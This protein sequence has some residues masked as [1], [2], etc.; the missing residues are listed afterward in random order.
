[1]KRLGVL[2]AL[3]LLHACALTPAQLAARAREDTTPNLCAATLVLSAAAVKAAEDELAARGAT[4]DWEQ[5]RAIAE[6]YLAR[7]QAARAAMFGMGMT[8]LQQSGPTQIAPAPTTTNCRWL[9]NVWNCTS[10]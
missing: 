1:M 9:G 3:P 7:Q 10:Y 4:C 8:M 2:A 5:A 6:T